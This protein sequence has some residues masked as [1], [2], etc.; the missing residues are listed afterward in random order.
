MTFASPLKSR[1]SAAWIVGLVSVLVYANSLGNGFA[2]DDVHIIVE[3]STIESLADLPETLMAPYWPVPDGAS[4]GLWRP[5]TTTLLA[6]Q[7]ALVGENPLLY[8]VVNVLGHAG[9]SILVLFLFAG[10]MSLPAA[11][12]GS[13][14]FAVHPVH[15]E[16][17]ANIIGVAEIV[18]TLLVLGACLLH[19][20]AR[21]P[22][23]WGRALAMGLLYLLAFGTKESAV[24]LPGVIFLLDAARGRIGFRELPG[25]L[26]ETWR[27]WLALV[28]AA[29][30]V[31]FMR[32]QILGSVADPQGA[33]GAEILADI[34]KI[35][36][37]GEIWSH[38]VRLM[39]FPLDLSADYSPEVI[40]VSW[41][42]TAVNVT[43]VVLALGIL[44][45]AWVAWRRGPMAQG[46]ITS[47]T[48]AFAVVWFLVTI[49]PVS[50]VLFLT[51]VLLAERTLY[52]PSVGIA[53]GMGWLVVRLARDRPRGAWVG[54]VLV[55]VLAS[56]RVWERNPTWRSTPIV[57]ERMIQDYPHS[58]RSQWVLGDLFFQ[59][60]RRSE[61]LT[62]YR[63]AI[64]LLG[65]HPKLIAE[66]GRRMIAAEYY[67][68]A[69]N[70]L[71][72][73]FRDH[74]D[75]SVAPGLIAVIRSEV[76]DAP[77]TERWARIALT[78]RPE[79]PVRQHLLAWSLA[80]QG[81]WEEAVEARRRAIEQGEGDYWQ[82]W[83]SL[84]YLEAWSGD[85][86]AA[87]YALDSAW[88]LAVTEGGAV[89]V[90][91]L[92]VELGVLPPNE[93]SEEPDGG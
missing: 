5:V 59:Q 85:T 20:E 28:V 90:D 82:Q 27:V 68:S 49:S 55:V 29:A 35:W 52:L 39:V 47:R 15:T 41:G 80:E 9:V 69:Q 57:F 16:S 33:L 58:G 62:S 89:Q 72:Y 10:L 70:L 36:T 45:G 93:R 79:D 4:L 54:L 51:G 74:P 31:L 76:G 26:R 37:L 40:P 60:G 14:L 42:W 19:L 8:H 2:Y 34:P 11:F 78:I 88:T 75:L 43:G 46:R 87:V 7:Y 92:F 83:M 18:S 48:A 13:L 53:A 21:R 6:V 25:Y 64:D 30:A 67:R 24:T 84:A 61:G 44:V 71:E 63:A 86:T 38:Y 56:A 23:G 65:T 66:V 22:V 91:S 73:S 1:H 17:V 32:F 12:A 3:N 77:G 50:N 81:R